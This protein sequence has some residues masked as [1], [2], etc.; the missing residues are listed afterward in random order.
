MKYL[1]TI[2]MIST[3]ML[4]AQAQKGK[5]T[6]ARWQKITTDK[7]SIKA[8]PPIVNITTTVSSP[9]PDG[10]TK[11]KSESVSVNTATGDTGSATVTTTVSPNGNVTVTEV[12]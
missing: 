1:F 3:C 2:L 8:H 5:K 6:E 4:S 12:D 7:G 11:I 9:Q 10:S